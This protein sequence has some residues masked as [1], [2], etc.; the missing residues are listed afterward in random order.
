M[1]FIE[2]ENER[3]Y[4]NRYDFI[5][6]SSWIDWKN[7]LNGQLVSYEIGTNSQG[8]CAKNIKIINISS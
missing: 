6:C 3:V 2:R 5:D 7:L 4:A 8:N 1:V